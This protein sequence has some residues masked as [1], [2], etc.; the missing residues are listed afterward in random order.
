MAV[1]YRHPSRETG[2]SC[3]SCG[4]PICPDCM[5]PTPVGMR[6]PECSRD[7]TKVKTIRTAP[8]TPIVTQALIV[9]NVIAFIAET[10]SG[11]SLGGNGAGSIYSHGAL[12]GPAIVHQHQYWR[13]VTAGFLHDGLL[14]IAVNMLS[15]YFVG[16]VL[17]PAIGSLNFAVIYFTSL[18]AGSFGALLFQP[19]AFTVGASG[20]IF[21]VFG[22]LIVVAHARG[23][24]IWQSGLAPVLVLNLVFSVSVSGISIGGHL[25]GLVAG[26]IAGWLVVEFGERRRMQSVVLLGCL[27]VA[28]LSVVG[29]LAVA[30]GHGLA[31]NGIGFTG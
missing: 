18:L 14:H 13:I 23:I 8:S 5:T 9:I 2:V 19:Q 12:F 22:A 21:G 30:G 24:P 7:R 1:C 27:V 11:A 15:L 26:L 28:A 20:A 17:E 29:A 16:R 31:P 25:G 3:S 4:R 6:C 10:A